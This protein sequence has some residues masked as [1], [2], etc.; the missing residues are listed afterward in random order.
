MARSFLL[1]FQESY[2]RSA[3]AVNSLSSKTDTKE[4]GE[5]PDRASGD[6]NPD[7][8]PTRVDATRTVTEV[9]G[10]GPDRS[11]QACSA[12][13]LTTARERSAIDTLTHTYVG[14][15]EPRRDERKLNTAQV[16]P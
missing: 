8:L 16:F 3:H 14:G 1:R 13:V 5:R 11:G 6:A 15:E 7:V 10:E 2:V 4:L 12:N 9:K